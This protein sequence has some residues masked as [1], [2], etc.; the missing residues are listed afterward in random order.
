MD[1]KEWLP[2]FKVSSESDKDLMKYFVKT[3]YLN[4]IVEG[5][6]WIVLGRKGTGKTAIFEYLKNVESN[7]INNYITVPLNFSDYPW[8]ILGF[9]KKQ[10]RGNLQHIRRVGNTYLSFNQYQN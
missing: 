1:I 7:Y 4:D 10:W 5:D 8:P 9:I 6:K 3:K 2:V